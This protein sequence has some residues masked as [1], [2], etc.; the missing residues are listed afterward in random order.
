MNQSELVQSIQE[1]RTRMQATLKDTERDLL[2]DILSRMV[3]GQDHTDFSE[4]DE[5]VTEFEVKH[6]KL[7]SSLREIIDSLSKMGI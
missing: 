4:L 2:G 3:K 7:A 5:Q 6:P 1:L